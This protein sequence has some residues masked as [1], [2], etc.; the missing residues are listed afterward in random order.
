MAK[1]KPKSDG[2]ENVA[3]GAGIVGMDKRLEATPRALA[4]GQEQCV[5]AWRADDML[6]RIVET[7]PDEMLREGWRIS[8]PD[9]SKLEQT[10]NDWQDDLDIPT[11][12]QSALH[13]GRALGGAGILLGAQDGGSWEEPL[14][15]ER[16]REYGFATVFTPQELIAETYYA[17]PLAARYGDVAT[18]R[19]SPVDV[20]TRGAGTIVTLAQPIIHESRIVRING[21]RT[22]RGQR[23][24]N[25]YPGWDDSVF[26]RVLQVVADFQQAWQGTSLLLH[27]FAPPVLKLK[28]LA[29]LLASVGSKALAERARGIELSRSVARVLILDSEEDYQR[30]TTN[31]TGLAEL[32][33]KLA[34]RVASAASMPVTLLMG[35]SPAGLQATGDADIRWFYD[36]VRS[37]QN[38]QLKTILRRILRPAFAA[39]G[40]RE[41]ESWDVV[42]TPLWQPSAKEE[43]DRRLVVAQTDDIYL[44]NQVVTSTEVGRSRF[45]GDEYSADTVIDV[46]LRDEMDRDRSAAI[47]ELLPAPTPP[48]PGFA[49]AQPP[50]SPEI[51]LEE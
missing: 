17:D 30:Q 44:R 16:V 6:A 2:W 47:E 51:E 43:A 15:P 29:K 11:H 4:L 38:G 1:R 37:R 33:D 25:V 26:V 32:L 45:G 50:P 31:V 7:V 35:Q 8:V 36:S 20:P 41:P 9:D 3:T 24:R 13:F 22:T 14:V 40:A 19:V 46:S 39:L 18:W 5:E 34:L 48:P 10:L 28:A 21:A 42:F 49:Q 27:D 23:L 12:L